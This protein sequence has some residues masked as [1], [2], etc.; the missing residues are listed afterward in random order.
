MKKLI[1]VYLLMFSIQSFGAICGCDAAPACGPRPPTCFQ[2]VGRSFLRKVFLEAGATNPTILSFADQIQYPNRVYVGWGRNTDG[3]PFGKYYVAF[4]SENTF[5]LLFSSFNSPRPVL[6]E[7]FDFTVGKTTN[8]IDS[9]RSRS[10][11]IFFP[12][13][14][15]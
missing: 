7:S 15:S 3:M 10:G 12:K 8:Q 9:I 11:K 13:G 14:E 6:V 2:H 1:F 4:T 5:S